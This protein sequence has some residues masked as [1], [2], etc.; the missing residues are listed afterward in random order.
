MAGALFILA[1]ATSRG[2]C[3]GRFRGA[4]YRIL[5]WTVVMIE[6]Y[7]RSRSSSRVDVDLIIN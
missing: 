6:T 3:L 1:S 7:G 5:S 2:M 4:W